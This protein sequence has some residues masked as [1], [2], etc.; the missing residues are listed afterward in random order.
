M[1]CRTEVK[2]IKA[3]PQVSINMNIC[4]GDSFTDIIPIA[5][6]YVTREERMGIENDLD[7]QGT[8]RWS[9]LL[10]K[11]Y[12]KKEY[13]EAGNCR[14]TVNQLFQCKCKMELYHK[15]AKIIQE[16]W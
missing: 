2:F 13:S 3:L 9:C 11:K 7:T 16:P 8:A 14:N 10:E 6:I 15:T 12:L 1:L 4:T 5:N